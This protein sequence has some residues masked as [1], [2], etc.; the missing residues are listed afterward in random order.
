MRYL[1]SRRIPHFSRVLLVE[2]GSRRILDK[3]LPHF[4][5]AYG[6]QVQLDVLTCFAADPAP[7]RSDKG[8]IL[9]V[10]EYSS[11][12]ARRRLLRELRSRRYAVLGIIC[13]NET[14]LARYKWSLA[15]LL[16]AKLLIINEN[17]DYFWVDRGN[18]R[19]IR[20]FVWHR[21]GI[22]GTGLWRTL[23]RAIIFPFTLTYLLL[24]AAAI[25]LRRQ[26][27]RL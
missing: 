16:P 15:A 1:L 3:L 24:F 12:S 23:A 20:G 27:R 25:H 2:S 14:L 5:E 7:F 18:L 11:A 10:Q 26:L 21:A 4:Y 8:D 22:A 9:R 17:G 13:S 19:A 6:A